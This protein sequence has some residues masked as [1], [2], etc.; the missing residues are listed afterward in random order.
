M[1]SHSLKPFEAVLFDMDGVLYIGDSMIAGAD[2]AVAFTRQSGLALAGVTN[3]TTQPRRVIAEKLKRLGIPIESH[4]I[5][6]P[7]ALAKQIIGNEEAKLFVRQA[8]LEDLDGL[9][10]NTDKPKYIVMGDLGDAGYT[11]QILREIFLDVMNGAKVLA[12]HKN[13]FWQ[14]ND[15]LHMDIGPYVSAIEYATNQDATILGKPSLDFFNEV[16]R[17]LNV[18]IS[19]TLMIGDDIESDIAGAIAANMYTALVK[20]G[21]YRA[22]FVKKTGIRAEYTLDDISG[23][24]DL[25]KNV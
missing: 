4:E 18:E 5:F 10:T 14:K 15:G 25:L 16:C 1:S 8:L 17:A 9:N 22:G 6:T 2:E 11:P 12:L 13:R 24:P 3:T 19:N 21:K 20:T 23:L 7:A